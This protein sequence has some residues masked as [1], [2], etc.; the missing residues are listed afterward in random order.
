[1]GFTKSLAREVGSRGITVNV[2]APG[3]INT[4][5]TSSLPDKL[6][7]A[8]VQQ[9]PLARVGEPEDVPLVAYTDTNEMMERLAKDHGQDA[10]EGLGNVY[11][12]LLKYKEILDKEMFKAPSS[13]RYAYC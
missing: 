9:I 2:V 11:T 1:M 7:E 12:Y 13:I 6:K 8:F 4:E 5:M 10:L 3:Y